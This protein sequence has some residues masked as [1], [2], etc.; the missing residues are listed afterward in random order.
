MRLIRGGYNGVP[1]EVALFSRSPVVVL[2]EASIN[3]ASNVHHVRITSEGP[4]VNARVSD[5]YTW[6]DELVTHDNT[7]VDCVAESLT[8]RQS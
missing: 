2:L 8:E 7:E 5:R 1:A 3:R 6:R 4:N